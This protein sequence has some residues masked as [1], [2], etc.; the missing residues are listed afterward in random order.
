M[1]RQTQLPDAREGVVAVNW[2]IAHLVGDYLLQNDWLANH[3]KGRLLP[4]RYDD[5]GSHDE[6]WSAEKAWS[7]GMIACFIHATLYTAAVAA[8]TWWPAWAIAAVFVTHF[9]QDRTAI[10]SWWMKTIGQ[11]NFAQPP[12]APW[13]VIVVD[14]VWHLLVLF[15]ISRAVALG[16][17]A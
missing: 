3:K 6:W 1:G 11:K 9:I 2:L 17:A 16:D 5:F 12:L 7:T 4:P 8:F 10:V 15:L 14:N 13:S